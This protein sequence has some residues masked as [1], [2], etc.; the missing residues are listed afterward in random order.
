MITEKELH[1]IRDAVENMKTEY[2]TFYIT[3]GMFSCRWTGNCFLWVYPSGRTTE[4]LNA[5]RLLKRIPKAPYG[6]KRDITNYCFDFGN[7][8]NNED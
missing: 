8:G 7:D 1:T 6:D 3:N 4:T 5:K 2:D